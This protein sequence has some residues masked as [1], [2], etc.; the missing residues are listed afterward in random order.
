MASQGNIVHRMAASRTPTKQ[1]RKAPSAFDLAR[2]QRAADSGTEAPDGT[3]WGIYVRIS[4]DTEGTSLG[5]ARQEKDCRKLAQDLGGT[6]VEVYN[7]NDKSAYRGKTRPDFSRMLRDIESGHINGVVFW[8]VDRLSRDYVHSAQ[9]TQLVERTNCRL[10]NVTGNADLSTSS[11]RFMFIVE[12]AVAQKA[13]D[14]ASERIKRKMLELRE[15]GRTTGGGRFYGWR[16][17]PCGHEDCTTMHAPFQIVREEAEIIRECCERVL[18]GESLNALTKDL[19]TRGTTTSRGRPWDR[20][21]VK[22]TLLRARNAGLV[23]ARDP[24]TKVMRVI[25]EATDWESIIDVDT[26]RSVKVVLE[27]SS[28]SKHWT[29]NKVRYLL[30]CIATCAECGDMMIAG[31]TRWKTKEGQSVARTYKCRSQNGACPNTRQSVVDAVV[32]ESLIRR[33][34]K[35]SPDE[36]LRV[37][38]DDEQVQIEQEI[39]QLKAKLEQYAIMLAHDDMTPAQ[40]TAAN[41]VM[42]EQLEAAELLRE[43]VRQEQVL[44]D[45]LGDRPVLEVWESLG[46]DRQRAVVKALCKEIRIAKG[47]KGRRADPQRVTIT[48]N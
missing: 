25:G 48:W 30:S 47:A 16:G 12:A 20:K 9:F 31:V 15:S 35:S 26:W 40:F 38:L 46:I 43:P 41:R 2:Q 36:L 27:D 17:A 14:D 28:R 10:A 1:S 32:V 21:T 3:R 33:I 19:N 5:V 44:R 24:Q 37:H 4:Q 7:D 29:N 45:F 42:R 11:G 39:V 23:E 13:S 6:V 8:K 34:E 18:A 22:V